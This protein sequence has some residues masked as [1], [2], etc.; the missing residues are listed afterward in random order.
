MRCR[1]SVHDTD[2]FTGWEQVVVALHSVTVSPTLYRNFI[3]HLRD[4]LAK[5]AAV[6]CANYVS[7]IGS[8][9]VALLYGASVSEFGFDCVFDRPMTRK[10]HSIEGVV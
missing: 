3:A 5:V 10:H 7:K 4:L 9:T 6:T 1:V 8:E 2:W